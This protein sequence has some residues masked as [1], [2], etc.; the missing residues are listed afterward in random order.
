[1]KKHNARRRSRTL[2]DSDYEAERARVIAR[3]EVCWLCRCADPPPKYDGTPSAD[4]E[5]AGVRSSKLK[6]SHLGCNS[7]RGDKTPQQFRAYLKTKFPNWWKVHH[8]NP[9]KR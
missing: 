2:Y 6:P 4:H 8:S 1:L 5:E 3:F 7:A 9:R